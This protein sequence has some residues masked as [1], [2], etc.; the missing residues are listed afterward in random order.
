MTRHPKNTPLAEWPSAWLK[1]E[2][3]SLLDDAIYIIMREDE[4]KAHHYPVTE[5]EMRNYIKSSQK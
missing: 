4:K 5:D 2:C 3:A 1:M